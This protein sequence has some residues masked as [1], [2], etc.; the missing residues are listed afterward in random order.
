MSA[1]VS[2][3]V[4]TSAGPQPGSAEDFTARLDSGD[5]KAIVAFFQGMTEKQ[6]R[7]FV[8]PLREHLK[9]LNWG[10]Y[11]STPGSDRLA[12]QLNWQHFSDRRQRG[13][14]TQLVAALAVHGGRAGTAKYVRTV[15][16]QAGLAP[17]AASIQQILSDR[18]P[19]W[20]PELAE[21]L[22]A[23]LAPEQGCAPLITAVA[24]LTGVV[25]A[26]SPAFVR[27]WTVGYQWGW[28][29]KTTKE[30]FLRDPRL[31]ELL[32]LVFDDDE[33]DGLFTGW[34]GHSDNERFPDFCDFNAAVVEAAATGRVPRAD[35]L[36]GVVRRLLR[37]GR[38]GAMQGQ[39]VLWNALEPTD[40]EI[41]ERISSC[42][43]LL[44]SQNGTVART[45]LAAVKRVSDAGLIDVEFAL[46]AASIAVTRPEK[47]V[48]KTVL[49]WLD[50]LATAQPDRLGAV[51]AAMATAFGAQAADLQERAVKLVGK[52]AKA[53]GEDDRRRLV[54]EAEVYLAPDLAATLAGLLGVSQDSTMGEVGYPDVAPYVP[55]PLLPP[56]GSPAELAEVVSSLIHAAPGEAMVFERVLEA[57]V[58]FERTDAEGL[59][60]A[61]APVVER[62][63]AEW[64]WEFGTAPQT[65]RLQLLR[66]AEAAAGLD[67]EARK[68]PHRAGVKQLWPLVRM[69]RAG[70]WN[71]TRTSPADFLILR[72]AEIHA[73]LGLP[74]LPPLVSVPT[75]PGGGIEPEVL[76]ARLRECESE[77]WVPLEA[78][79]HQA[80]LRLPEDCAGV[81][82]SGLTSKAGLRFAAWVAGERI[83]LPAGE[84][85]N[86]LDR[87]REHVRQL[88][89]QSIRKQKRSH[90]PDP[91]TLLDLAPGVWHLPER[92]WDQS[93]WD[94]CWPA[95]MPAR[96]HLAAMALI[97]TADWSTTT[98]SAESAVVLAEQDGPHTATH[99]VIAARLADED[100]RMRASGVDAALVLA[101]RGLL[102]PATLGAALAHEL[103]VPS[104]PGVRR[105]TPCLRDL[106]NGGAAGQTWEAIAHL[107]PRVLPPALPK[108]LTGTADLLVLAT[109]LAGALQ[110][111]TSIA[112]VGALAQK[113]SSST[114]ANAARRLEAVLRAG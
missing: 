27:L 21:E 24:E 65:P 4:T 66:V 25:P 63:K 28:N 111:R 78:D 112:E 60:T 99:Q 10:A 6:R 94:L 55:R 76:A 41:V 29:G 47:N 72:A 14:R 96:P 51:V 52:R 86:P 20:L 18:D 74:D 98:P 37:G 46:E 34:G 81:D 50:G 91:E 73:A 85:P 1:T 43:S 26:A 3:V 113:K 92:Q 19:A 61:L 53:L 71:R 5:T 67:A 31:A 109:E 57:F 97:G 36:D 83:E 16:R 59:K 40:A 107:L 35:V 38:T 114:V 44:S 12:H 84:P 45:S 13:G 33:N 54:A 30:A 42:I 70:W 105:A 62:Q 77:G 82:A 32:P 48:V 17:D 104:G 69:A 2:A 79:F 7:A 93:D 58:V 11:I 101:S 102:D 68:H 64:H 108:T 75:S 89:A 88:R 49:S 23:V 80:L 100:A 87:D 39:L 15:Q 8:P 110:V 106:A 9:T 90:V 56:I 22:I 103:A 95:I